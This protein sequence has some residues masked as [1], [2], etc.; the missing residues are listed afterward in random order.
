[1]E[2]IRE[3]QQSDPKRQMLRHTV[4]T[5]AY[6]GAKALRDAPGGGFAQFQLAETTR[7]PGE[8]LAHVGDLL[9]WALALAQGRQDWKDS[10]P[11][12]WEAECG[13]SLAPWTRSI[14]T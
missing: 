10:P 3:E 9:D 11:V 1:M 8:I 5:L 7:T 12:E 13:V 6:R 2:Q 14:F 4:A